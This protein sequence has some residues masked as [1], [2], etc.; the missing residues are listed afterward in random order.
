M[1]FCFVILLY[2]RYILIEAVFLSTSLITVKKIL[3][4][5]SHLVISSSYLE[6]KSQHNG[7]N[8]PTASSKKVTYY[9]LVA[10]DVINDLIV[11]SIGKYNIFYYKGINRINDN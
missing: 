11:L 1:S 2:C 6:V 9:V 7:Q 3:V 8:L 5:R 10:Y 4:W